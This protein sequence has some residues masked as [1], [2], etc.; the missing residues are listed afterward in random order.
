[1]KEGKN[2]GP[3]TD[4]KYKEPGDADFVWI[5]DMI[6][7]LGVFPHNL[8]TA[9][10]VVVGDLVYV[11]TSNGVDEGHLNCPRPTPRSSSP[12]TRTPAKSSASQ[13]PW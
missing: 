1:L 13:R 10:P 2:T 8:A 5:L 7:E 11:L 4:E 9:S 12:S 3:F 6:D